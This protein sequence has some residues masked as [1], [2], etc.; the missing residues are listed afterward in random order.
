MNIL[1]LS[2]KDSTNFAMSKIIK[3]FVDKGHNVIAYTKYTDKHNIRQIEQFNIKVHHISEMTEETVDKCDIA[4]VHTMYKGNPMLLRKKYLFFFN[5]IFM[6]G[7]NNMSDFMFVQ[8]NDPY[9]KYENKVVF[10]IGSPKYDRIYKTDISTEESKQILFIETGHFPFGEKGRRQVSKM[11]LDIC[12]N[13]KDY[14]IVVKPRFFPNDKNMTRRNTDHIY[15][16]IYDLCDNNLP[17]NLTLLYKHIDLEQEIYKSHSIVCYGTSAYLEAALSGR[18][19]VVVKGIES[20]EIYDD[21]KEKY[22]KYLYDFI[23]DS[24]CVVDIDKVNEYLPDGIKCSEKHLKKA[25][26]H[27]GNTSER[28]VEIVEYV[29]E[30]FLSNG[31][32][33]MPGEYD[34]SDY[35]ERLIPKYSIDTNQLVENKIINS[36]ETLIHLMEAQISVYIDWQELYSII[37]TWKNDKKLKMDDFDGLMNTFN[38]YIHSLIVKNKNLLLNDYLDSLVLLRSLDNR[39]M[40]DKIEHLENVLP[41]AKAS[42]FYFGK[43]AF[44]KSDYKKSMDYFMTYFKYIKNMSYDESF[45]CNANPIKAALQW[46]VEASTYEADDERIIELKEVLRDWQNESFN[47]Y[48]YLD[49]LLNE[50]PSA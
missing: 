42:D 50:K 10:K 44:M 31:L 22:W 34:Y 33:P 23:E 27:I 18:G 35:K 24:G 16:Y 30:N 25:V 45:L 12:A 3:A 11:L 39:H 15:K 13:N 21:R 1:F 32:Y 19:L 2:S 40:Y 9:R 7:H 4:F 47:L 41:H 46:Y 38:G 49:E 29:W 20:N 28:I 26:A 37:N 48:N 43:A 17:D 36:L 6:Y 5:H 8:C 14:R